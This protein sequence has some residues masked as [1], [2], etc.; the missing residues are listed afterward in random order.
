M[1]AQ[2]S[3]IEQCELLRSDLLQNDLDIEGEFASE[4]TMRDEWQW[5]E[6]LVQP[7]WVVQFTLFPSIQPPPNLRA[8]IAAVKAEA[9]KNPRECMRTGGAGEVFASHTQQERSL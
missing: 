6:W 9:R 3:F 1:S 4:A 8:R 5:S 7:S 2:E